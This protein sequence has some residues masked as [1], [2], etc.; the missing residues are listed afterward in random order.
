[1]N[2]EDNFYDPDDIRRRGATNL[3][4][5]FYWR[6]IYQADKDNYLILPFM[7]I[8]NSDTGRA[9]YME[10]QV[11]QNHIVRYHDEYKDF[12]KKQSLNRREFSRAE[13]MHIQN[14]RDKVEYNKSMILLPPEH[15]D[16]TTLIS[17]FSL[18]LNP[19]DVAKLNAIDGV[20]IEEEKKPET[21]SR[22]ERLLD[23]LNLVAD[24]LDRMDERISALENR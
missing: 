23:A 14:F 20:Q 2:K 18:R 10:I 24:K 6:A 1:M 8:N 9:D 4:P 13:M 19:E 17:D 11:L 5:Q 7:H 15:P 16:Y 21:K 3:R 22:D 12:M